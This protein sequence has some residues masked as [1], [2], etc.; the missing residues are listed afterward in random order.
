MC[1]MFMG[2]RFYKMRLV[3]ISAA[4]SKTKH[5]LLFDSRVSIVRISPI[6]TINFEKNVG[7]C[8]QIQVMKEK[9][10]YRSAIRSKESIRKAYLELMREQNTTAISVRELVDRANINRSTFYAHYQDIFAVLEE[11]ETEITQK[12]FAFFDAADHAEWLNSPL[13]FLMRIGEELEQ[14]KEFYRLLLATQGSVTFMHKLQDAFLKRMVTER[15]VFGKIAR[16]EE[17]FIS[18]RMVTGGMVV[19]FMDW[20]SG[21]IKLPLPEVMNILSNVALSATQDYV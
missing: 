20:V 16:Q 17:F 11:I 1:A 18:M 10:E 2:A 8:P 5:M 13:P 7:F 9:A 6:S 14:N 4:Q 15:A 12:L 21:K 3:T 19:I